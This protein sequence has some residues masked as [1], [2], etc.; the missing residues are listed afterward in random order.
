MIKVYECW[1]LMDENGYSEKDITLELWG[2]STKHP[3]SKFY[4][5]DFQKS[6][7][8]EE[9]H[10]DFQWLLECA[11]KLT[12]PMHAKE[13]AEFALKNYITWE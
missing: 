11:S 8:V 6:P 1:T 9:K 4:F 2:A 5:S 10:Q 7:F 12:F 3:D 13:L